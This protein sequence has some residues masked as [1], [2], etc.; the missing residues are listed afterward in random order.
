[1]DTEL[2]AKFVDIDKDGIRTKLKNLG[3]TLVYPE[4]QMRRKVY[5]H[6]T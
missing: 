4:R 3:A 5:K 6:T 1:M 2:E